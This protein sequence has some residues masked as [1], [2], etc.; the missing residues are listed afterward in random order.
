[1]FIRVPARRLIEK[2]LEPFA[3]REQ[4]IAEMTRSVCDHMLSESVDR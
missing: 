3:E 2:S 4:V 1:M